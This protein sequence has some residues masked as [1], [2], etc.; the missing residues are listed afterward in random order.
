MKTWP[1]LSLLLACLV[2][3]LSCARVMRSLK[4]PTTVE[5]EQKSLPS[6][7]VPIHCARPADQGL[8]LVGPSTEAQK[9]FQAFLRQVPSSTKLSFVDQAVL[10]ALFQTKV[11]PDFASPTARLQFLSRTSLGTRYW[12]FTG[13]G[14]GPESYPFLQGLSAF[15]ASHG[16][17]RRLAWYARLLD[18]HLSGS[19]PA[20]RA[21]EEHLRTMER[22]IAADPTLRRHWFRGD[23][24]LRENERLPAVPL[25]PFMA[26]PHDPP[27]VPMPSLFTYRRT[28]RLDVRC[29]YD[30]TLYDNSIFLIDKGE[31]QG[32]LFGLTAGEG[33]FL[34]VAAQKA[35]PTAS[36]AGS[37]VFKGDPR[38]RSAAFCVLQRPEGEVWLAANQSRDPGQHVYHLFRYGL[39][40][41]QTPEA[42]ETLIRHARHMF[43]SD[44][45]RLVIESARS[46]EDQVRDLLKLNVP[47]YNANAIGN[48]WAWARFER[49]RGGRFFMDDRN[50]GALLCP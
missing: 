40:H 36:L 48:I 14:A 11:R 37:P 30:F 24:L 21:L 49:E 41:S 22:A 15:L 32:H 18:Q 27:A 46:R 29:N 9:V 38:V 23:E 7:Q 44:P 20:G 12:D 4:L 42:I 8:S 39:M 1:K 13:A 26:L 28:P 34:A 25:S 2:G 5:K 33:S 6:E 35:G 47:I 3:T 45:L 17:K 19:V 31:N 16:E 10:W 50:P 43:L